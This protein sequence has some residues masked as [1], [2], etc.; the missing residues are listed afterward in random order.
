MYYYDDIFEDLEEC[1]LI[2]ICYLYE[3]YGFL[4]LDDLGWFC[5]GFIY[6]NWVFDNLW[7]DGLYCG[8]NN[9]ISIL[10]VIGCYV[11]FMMLLVFDCM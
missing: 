11:D 3:D 4:S 1:F 8:V 10:K 7:L 2:F 6:G 5:Y 9:E